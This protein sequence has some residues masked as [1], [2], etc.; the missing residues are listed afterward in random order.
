M[1]WW[2]LN[3]WNGGWGTGTFIWGLFSMI[4]QIAVIIGVIYLV[5]HLININGNGHRKGNDAL[6]ILKER[7]ARGEISEE[8]YEEKKKRLEEK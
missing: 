6:E 5:I 2:M 8:E 3:G 4:I 1:M 7:Y